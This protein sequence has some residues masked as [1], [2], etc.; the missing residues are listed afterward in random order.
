MCTAK[1]LLS[2]LSVVSTIIFLLLC[3]VTTG[4]STG[5]RSI[6]CS[7]SKYPM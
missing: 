2:L 4:L 7:I 6:V 5:I 1:E 3:K